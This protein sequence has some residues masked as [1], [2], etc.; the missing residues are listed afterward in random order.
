VSKSIKAD[1]GTVVTRSRVYA[2]WLTVVRGYRLIRRTQMPQTGSFGRVRFLD[3]WWFE[4]EQKAGE[5]K[6]AAGHPREGDHMR[7]GQKT[8]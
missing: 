5:A 8:L 1:G 3:T 2:W 6:K 7:R 4:P